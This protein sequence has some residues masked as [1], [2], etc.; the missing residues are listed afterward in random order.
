MPSN[1]LRWL[2][3]F[4]DMD[5]EQQ[6]VVN[7]TLKPGTSLIYGPAGSGKTAITLYC[8]KMLLDLGRSFKVFVYTNVLHRFILAGASD[9][10][11]PPDSI[12]TFYR[13]VRE[14]Y[15]V[16]IGPPPNISDD[17]F[18]LWVDGLIRHWSTNGARKP[19]FDYILVDEAQD[20]RPNVARLLHMLTPNV[21][22][23][24]D[25]MQSLYVDTSDIKEL[26]SRWG[27]VA[28]QREV[29]RNYRNPVAVAR[30]AATFADGFGINAQ[31]FLKRVKGKPYDQKPI[32]YQ[33]D[34]R[35]A[36]SAKICEIIQQARGSVRI[37]ILC[38]HQ[39]Q[40]YEEFKRLQG[41][42]M[43]VQ[44]ALTREEGYDFNN[45]APVLTTAHSAKGLEFD[46]V[47]LPYLTENGWDGDPTD[48]K[49]RRLFFVAMTRAKERLYLISQGGDECTFLREI[50]AKGP[51]LLQQP[52]RTF[53]AQ[54]PK[55]HVSDFDDPF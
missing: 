2:M 5:H 43:R 29:P 28:Y 37:G 32:W 3:P 12:T 14:Q 49:E 20:F 24:A 1:A 46:W 52:V 40:I 55:V 38:R 13:W 6:D 22:V 23:V 11:L 21:F 36:Q 50:L 10:G 41:L 42:D 47:V 8:A 51:D 26:N 48:P 53:S 7:N 31:D 9:L 39:D 19:S 4:R 17:K 30:V 16:Q 35:A 18:S 25:P 45:P 33:V 27:P 54:V 15:K 44:I 34:S